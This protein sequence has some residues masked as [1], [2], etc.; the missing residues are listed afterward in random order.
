MIALARIFMYCS[1]PLTP[2]SPFVSHVS[3]EMISSCWLADPT[4]RPKF[5]ELV[6]RLHDVMDSDLSYLTLL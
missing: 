4:Q 3:W 6:S 5:S 1:L 2:L